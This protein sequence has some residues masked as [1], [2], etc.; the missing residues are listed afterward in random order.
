M[1]LALLL[2]ALVAGVGL[3]HIIVDGSI[4]AKWRGSLIERYRDTR[5]WVVELISCYQCTGFWAGALMGL[6]LQPISWGLFDHLWWWLALLISLPLWLLVTP[7]IVGC[8]VSYASMV[9]AAFLN[10]LDAPAMAIAAKKKD[11]SNKA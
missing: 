5:P 11:E 7:V 3:S 10:W 6:A 2:L 8:G 1:T 9:G 4:F